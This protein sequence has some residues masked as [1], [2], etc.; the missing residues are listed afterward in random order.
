MKSYTQY[1]A[2]S[3]KTWKFCIKTI[4]QLS[5]E[6][7]DR[8]EKH[9]MKYDSNGLGAEKKTILQSKPRDFPKYRG[10]EVY[11][12]DFETSLSTTPAQVQNE[13]GNMLGLRDGV[14]KVKGEHEIG[15]EDIVDDDNDA[16]SLLADPDYKEAEKTNA[17]E[18]AGEEYNAG[19]MKELLKLKKE[20]GNE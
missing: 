15:Y 14:L 18:L 12:Y 4:N 17:N 16:E 19:L 1:L 3:T 7:A 11:S 10:Y 20:K 6:Q 9:L 5:D 2:E 8:I 13:I